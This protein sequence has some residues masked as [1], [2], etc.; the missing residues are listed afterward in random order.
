MRR[1]EYYGAW[2]ISQA[3]FYDGL[4]FCRCDVYRLDAAGIDGK[5]KH[6]EKPSLQIAFRYWLAEVVWGGQKSNGMVFLRDSGVT[7][8][9]AVFYKSDCSLSGNDML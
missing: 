3:I 7:R 6:L 8:L 4:P 1:T 2:R 9:F 5:E